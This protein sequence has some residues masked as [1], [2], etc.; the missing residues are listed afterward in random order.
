MELRIREWEKLKFVDPE[1]ILRGLRE[2]AATQPLH[3]LPYEV[4]SLR[5]RDLRPYH[6]GRQAALFCYGMSQVLRTPV[7]FAQAENSDYDVIA[8][9]VL[10]DTAHYVPVQLKELVPATLNPDADLQSELD[11]ISK[12]VDSRD[13]VVAFH[14]NGDRRVEFWKLRMPTNTIGGLWFYGAKAP[15]QRNWLLIGDM[16]KEQNDAHEFQHPGA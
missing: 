14:L 2:I 10:G 7:V 1:P 11:K 15:D 6:E 9:Y 16:L 4:R 8:R 13:L 3:E 5:R 12:Y